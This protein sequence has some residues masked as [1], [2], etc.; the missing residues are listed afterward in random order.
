MSNAKDFTL[1]SGGATGTEAFFGELAERYGMQ[2]VNFSFEGH[3]I[4][5]KRGIRILTAEELSRK[6]VS[7]AYVSRL[8]NRSYTEDPLLH[9]VLKSICWQVSNGDEVFVVGEIIEDGT[10]KGGTGWGAEFA[11][12]CNKPLHAFDQQQH[13]W[14]TW[15]GAQWVSSKNIRITS[16]HFTATGSRVLEKSGK[17]AIQDLFARTFG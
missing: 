8:M 12:I 10:I 6:D 17:K 15:Q 13:S 14:F 11:K 9:N 2:E 5:R 4:E 3:D 1:Y 7:L 16:R